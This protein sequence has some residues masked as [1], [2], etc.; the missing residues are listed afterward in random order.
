M[1]AILRAHLVSLPPKFLARVEV[2]VIQKKTVQT[3]VL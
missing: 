2:F 3:L 1:G